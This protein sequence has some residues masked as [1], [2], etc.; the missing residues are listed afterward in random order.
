MSEHEM[1][2]STGFSLIAKASRTRSITGGVI[3]DA[4]GAGKTVISIALILQGLEEARAS[5]SFPRRTSASL[6]V[7]PSS[8][9]AQWKNEIEKFTTGLNVL[10]IHDATDI[11]KTTVQ[12]I[13]EADVVVC[14]VDIIESRGYTDIL[15]AKSGL[16]KSKDDAM[17]KI[18]ELPKAMGQQEKPGI[19]GVWVPATSQDPYG[20]GA[21]NEMKSQ[22]LRD[23]SAYF[24]HSYLEAVKLIRQKDFKKTDKGIPLEYFEWERIVV[25]EI[26]ECLC[27]EKD[28]LQLDWFKEK[29]RRASREL[30]GITQ[31]DVTQRP[32]VYRK[33]IFGLTGTPLLDNSSRVIELANLIGCTYII[34]LA[35]H[36]RKLERESRRDIFL[37]HFL[38]PKQSR[39]IRKA[40]YSKCQE[41]LKVA[42]CRNTTEKEL[43]GIEKVEEN[44]PIS[45]SEEEKQMYLDSQHGLE[46][47]IRSLSIRPE[48]FDPSA[49]HDI[50]KFLR[51]NAD[52]P[53]RGKA[54]VEICQ[55][56]LAQDETT[57]II[58]FADGR[59]GAGIA[60][61]SFLEEAG[62]GCTY[63]DLE[64]SVATQN[65]KISYYQR[66][67][68]TQEDR[69]RPRVLV[70]HFDHAAG[71]NLQ[72]E[73]Y[74]MILFNP[75]YVGDGGVT[76]EPVSDASTEQQAI[77]RVFRPG[78]LRPQVH[79]YR[80]EVRGPNGEE[81]LDGYVIRRNTDTNTLAATTNAGEAE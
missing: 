67:D 60:A 11:Q 20:R 24:T 70:L 31:K 16:T 64:D 79:V 40:I 54:L 35:S 8:L 39:E 66:P 42:C 27:T 13:L 59:I 29:N 74:N 37:Q 30:L 55:K 26:H 18:P 28:N 7:V 48:N 77:G 53:A 1:P 33:S 41:Y 76:S 19:S 4:I 68:S 14:P 38:E 78:Q 63:L 49:G 25:D 36:W 46:R 80:I 44:Y 3:A 65:E 21:Q 9:V 52:L 45:M 51:Q 69:E 50:S 12:R 81:C 71:L 15:T 43:E 6:V 23:L 58:V 75:L 32:L 57:K 34:G 62:L 5:R 22:K 61:R 17:K 47:R 2:G 10:C 73:C 56:I 72:K